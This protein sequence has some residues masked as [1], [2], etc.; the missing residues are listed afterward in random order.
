MLRISAHVLF[1]LHHELAG[2][3]NHESTHPMPPAVA[4]GRSEFG[5]DGQHERRCLSRARLRDPDQ[6]VPRKNVRDRGH[7]NRGRFGVAGFLH[8]L[9]N[10][11][12]QIESA[13]RHKPGTIVGSGRIASL[14]WALAAAPLSL[15]RY[16]L[17]ANYLHG[18]FISSHFAA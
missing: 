3:R 8:G 4:A 18:P 11:R 1:D 6:I 10:L 2:R 15:I 16:S 5:Q 7:L 13:K 12:G 17:A 9:E 14:I